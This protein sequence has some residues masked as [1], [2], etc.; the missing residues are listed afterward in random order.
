MEVLIIMVNKRKP[1]TRLL[2]HAMKVVRSFEGEPF[3]TTEVHSHWEA[4]ASPRMR[5]TQRGVVGLMR[6][7]HA[8]GLIKRCLDSEEVTSMEGG[9]YSV[10]LWREITLD[11]KHN[12]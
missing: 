6:N 5:P 4:Y 7:L 9:H 12:D 10:V 1:K 2:E 11:G 8:K 3:T